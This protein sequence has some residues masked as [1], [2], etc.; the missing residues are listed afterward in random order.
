MRQYNY[1]SLA[2]GTWEAEEIHEKWNST[3]RLLVTIVAMDGEGK[4][5]QNISIMPAREFLW[6]RAFTLMNPPRITL[7]SLDS[8][9]PGVVSPQELGDVRLLGAHR[10]RDS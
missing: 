9:V 2:C 7:H 3:Q 4:K 8:S 10:S 5:T 1:A 6:S